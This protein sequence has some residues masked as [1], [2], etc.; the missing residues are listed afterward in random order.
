MC[1]R[2]STTNRRRPSTSGESPNMI[3]VCSFQSAAT[4]Q[5]WD[6][7]RL[8]PRKFGKL[9]SDFFGTNQTFWDTKRFDYPTKFWD[10]LLPKKP[11]KCWLPIQ[12]LKM[13]VPWETVIFYSLRTKPNT[14]VGSFLRI[15]ELQQPDWRQTKKSYKF[16]FPLICKK[17]TWYHEEPTYLRPP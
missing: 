3:F 10:W 12:T 14:E 6:L 8:R 15:F 5:L 17:K 16:I 2:A 13:V 9:Y 4:I 11:I 7:L 1:C